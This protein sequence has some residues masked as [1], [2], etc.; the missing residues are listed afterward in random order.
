MIGAPAEWTSVQPGESITVR[1]DRPGFQ[2]SAE[3]VA[4]AIGFWPCGSSPCSNVGY[5]DEVLGNVVYNGP[6]DPEYH[7]GQPTSA[8]Y[9]NFTVTV[10][11]AFQPGQQISLNVAHFTLIGAE[12]MPYMEVKNIT[13]LL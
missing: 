11:S 9:Q 12:F 7:T 1:V 5:L 3:E 8:Q 6:Y 2:S 4:V 13:L 10:P